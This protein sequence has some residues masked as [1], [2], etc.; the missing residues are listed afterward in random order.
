MKTRLLI[1]IVA[2]ATTEARS[3]ADRSRVVKARNTG[4]NRDHGKPIAGP[5][6][7]VER[8]DLYDQ[9]LQRATKNNNNNKQQQKPVENKAPWQMDIPKL[10]NDENE[11]EKMS[12]SS[13]SREEHRKLSSQLTGCCYNYQ[14]YSASE[15]CYTYGQ[16][17]ES[18]E[19]PSHDDDRWRLFSRWLEFYRTLLFRQHGQRKSVFLPIV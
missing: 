8:A 10:G 17:C 15:L 13:L 12:L 9:A 19:T 11:N 7:R 14:S 1:I 18:G 4:T 6:Y 5:A 3:L 2:L 16:D